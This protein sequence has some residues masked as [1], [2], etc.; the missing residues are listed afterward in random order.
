MILTEK[1]KNKIVENNKK[2]TT[3][4]NENEDILREAG[5]NPPIDNYALDRTEKIVFPAGYIRTVAAFNLKYHLQEICPNRAI[6][7]NITYA[8]EASD[9]INF[10]MNRVN[11][12]GSV[13]TIFFKLAI[14]NFV[15]I[16]EAIL[17]EATNNICCNASACG[18]TKSCYY[19]FSRDERNNARKAVEKLTQIGILDFDS[20]KVSRVQEIIDL[21]NRIHIRLTKG[22]E[23]KLD[24]FTLTLYNE[25][26]TLL[27][28]IDEQIYKKAV[29]HYGCS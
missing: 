12:W 22:N 29:P 17:L 10:V 9:L 28:D 1:A 11:I 14:V 15:S 27:Q 8:L 16:M 26:V 19:H 7:H 2:I 20:E 13:E 5:Y 23:M 4:L 24:D 3:L 18:K 6:R 21:R 25:V